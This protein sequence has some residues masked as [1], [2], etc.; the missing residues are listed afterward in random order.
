MQTQRDHVHAHQFMMGRLSSALVQGDPSTAE[1]PGQ[2]AVT[3]LAFG[4][5]I[6]VLVVAGFAVYGWIVPGGSKAYTKSGVILVEKESGNRYVYLDGVL[7]PTPNLTSAMLIQGSGATVKL[8]SK[9]SIKDVPRGPSIGI[10]GAPQSVATGSM[11]A[12]PWLACLPGSVADEPG[13]RLGL[14]LDPRAEAVPLPTDRFAVVRAADGPTYLVTAGR[15]H[16][17]ADPAVLAALGA[18]TTRKVPAPQDWLDFLPD[19]PDL[20]PAEIP[21]E[22]RS[23]RV[24]GRSYPIGTLFRQRPDT[25][26]EQLLV[27]RR[28]G[29]APLSRTEFLLATATSGEEPVELS[30]ADLAAARMSADRSLLTRLPDLTG[31]TPQEPGPYALCLRQSAVDG[32]RFDSTAVLVPLARSGVRPDGRT[33]VLLAPGSGMAVLPAP[34]GPGAAQP[35]PTYIADDGKAYPIGDQD[36]VRALKL[37]RVVSV[38]FPRELLALV[39]QGPALGMRALAAAEVG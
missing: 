22:G 18:T 15:R 35:L 38:P 16:R 5:L 17:V 31:L 32:T 4:V 34:V 21:G 20:A 39:P 10:D 25:G 23:G 19:G 2:R 27:L 37:D 9:E 6:S 14:N 12:G 28:D 36:A 3:G 7:R 30:A 1:I 33:T 29:L 11:V 26:A 8:I 24:G 13:D